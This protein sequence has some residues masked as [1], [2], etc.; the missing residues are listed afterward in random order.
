MGLVITEETFI[1]ALLCDTV[2]N[3]GLYS[4]ERPLCSMLYDEDVVEELN[5]KMSVI[6]FKHY[7][8]HER[9]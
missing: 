4:T 2:S 6:H 5:L 3:L 8:L 1:C 7:T 9:P